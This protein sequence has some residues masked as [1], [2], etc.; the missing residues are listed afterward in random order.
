RH[1]ALAILD[2]KTGEVFEKRI[3]VREQAIEYYRKIGI[4]ELEYDDPGDEVNV[5]VQWWNSFNSYFVFPDDKDLVVVANRYRL[6]S[7]YLNGLPE[8]SAGQYTDII[9]SPYSRSLHLPSIIEKGKQYLED[10][11]DRAFEQLEARKV[12]SKSSPESIITA[13]VDKDFIKNIILVE[14]VDPQGFIIAADGGKEL[15]E[16]VLTV[17]GSNEERAYRYTGSPAGASG[18]AQ[19]IKPTYDNMVI[20]YPEAKLIKDYNMGMADHVN[21]VK[22]MVLFFDLH[23]K[24]I[25]NKVTRQDIIAQIGITEEMLAAA[26][27]GGPGRVV[28]SVNKYGMAWITSQLNLPRETVFREET[29][30][31]IK[32]FEAIKSLNIFKVN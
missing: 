19:F 20:Q 1:I 16:R 13:T 14:H 11:V 31:Y 18:M 23:K 7:S 17:I 8:R 12:F 4:L 2:K 26:Y 10:K 24:D 27:N 29:V 21:A 9:Y 30:N 25:A 32:K 6:P 3:W 5:E 22:A 28:S 15:T